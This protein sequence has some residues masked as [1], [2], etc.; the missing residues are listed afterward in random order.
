MAAETS[1]TFIPPHQEYVGPLVNTNTTVEVGCIYHTPSVMH[2]R[3]L[4]LAC[5]VRSSVSGDAIPCHSGDTA[6]GPL[7]TRA[8]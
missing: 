5:D 2:C 3:S 8:S 6:H 1:P 4:V 7:T